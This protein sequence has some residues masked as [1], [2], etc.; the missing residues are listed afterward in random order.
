MAAP[1]TPK[2][3]PTITVSA[4]PSTGRD[5]PQPTPVAW[6]LLGTTLEA[7]EDGTLTATLPAFNTKPDGL[8]ATGSD[9]TEITLTLTD[10]V[11]THP[12]LGLTTGTSTLTATK[13]D[14]HP[15]VSIPAT[16]SMGEETK[17]SDGTPFA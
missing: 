8:K 12:K 6:T 13:T 2:P 15:A 11:E 16:W 1:A 4:D 10:P 9:G 17:L 14:T 5:E 3:A 7:G